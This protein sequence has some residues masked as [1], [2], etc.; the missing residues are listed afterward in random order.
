MKSASQVE[1]ACHIGALLGSAEYELINKFSRFGHAL[2]MITQ[3]ANDIHGIT[4]GNDIATRKIT[5]PVIFALAHAEEKDRQQLELVFNKKSGAVPNSSKIL[6]LLFRAGAIHYATVKVEYYQQCASD[7][8]SEI[9]KTG[10]RVERLKL[11]L[12]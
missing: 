1:C 10:A 8:L 5:L 7:I 6:D 12:E 4:R 9:E 2:G 3:I 11:F